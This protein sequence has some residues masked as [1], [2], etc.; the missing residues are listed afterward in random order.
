MAVSFTVTYN[1][2]LLCLF[3]SGGVLIT[4]ANIHHS[5][6]ITKTKLDRRHINM[7]NMKYLKNRIKFAQIKIKKEIFNNTPKEK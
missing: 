4:L 2:K 3:V 1:R 5:Y 6:K 7:I